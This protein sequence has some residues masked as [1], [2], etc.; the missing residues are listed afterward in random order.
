MSS[1]PMNSLYASWRI[2]GSYFNEVIHCGPDYNDWVGNA[3]RYLP[4]EIFDENKDKLAFI[5]TVQVDACR[6]ARY[7]C[8]NKELILLSHRIFPKA[9]EGEG[10][11]NGKYFIFTVL[12]EVAHAIQKHGSPLFDNLEQEEIKEQ[13]KEADE[14]ALKWFNVH[15]LSINP[16]LP[17]LTMEEIKT[18]QAK[19]QELMRENK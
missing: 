2:K 16:D 4:E 10:H 5:S 14:L 18:A 7:L 11:S 15:L 17:P 9:G 12:H 1:K 6:V 19:N 13:E 8:E 3:L